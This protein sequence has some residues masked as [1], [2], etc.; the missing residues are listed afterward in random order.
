MCSGFIYALAV[1]S[2]FLTLN[3]ARTAVVIGSETFSRLLDWRDRR[4]CVLFGDGA[5][6]VVLR[7]ERRQTP[8]DRGVLATHLVRTAAI[9]RI[10]TWTAARRPRHHRPSADERPRGVPSA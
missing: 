2:N 7:A 5:G 3:Q 9:T 10:S 4:T 6:A 8:F 1:A